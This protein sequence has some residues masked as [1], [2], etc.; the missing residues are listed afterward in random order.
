MITSAI[1]NN[2][3]TYITNLRRLRQHGYFLTDYQLQAKSL[4]SP[5]FLQELA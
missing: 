2:Y 5:T 4:A 1:I 3:M